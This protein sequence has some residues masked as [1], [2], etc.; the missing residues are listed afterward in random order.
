LIIGATSA[1]AEATGRRLAQVGDAV[2]LVARNEQKV[3]AVR[4]D[5]ALRGASWVGAAVMDAVDHG[6]HQGVI[7]EARAAMGGLDVVLIA[8][9]VLPD[10]G[11]SQGSYAQTLECFEVNALG[12]ISLLTRLAG[13]LEE[14]GSGAVVVITSVAGDRGRASNYVYGSA[15]GAVTIFL[16]GL[17]NRLHKSGVRV[18][19]VKPGFVDSPMTRGFEKGVLWSKPD[20]IAAGIVRS[21]G[22]SK[23]VVYLPFYWRWIMLVIRLIP[24]RVF[25]RMS[26]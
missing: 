2:F 13:Y 14:Q 6:A 11:A 15:K 4:D 18:I 3:A 25:K 1:I 20:Q 22:R 17:R 16:Q 9:G 26:L 19:T 5:L 24:E 7:E 12:V 23:D 21:L 10:Q 8:H